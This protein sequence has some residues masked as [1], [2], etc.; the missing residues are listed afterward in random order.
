MRHLALAAAVSAA[1]LL[2]GC[3]TSTNNQQAGTSSPVAEQS[4]AKDVAIAGVRLVDSYTPKA[5]EVAIAY[6]K[7]ELDNGLTVI[8]H[9]DHSDPLVDVDVTYHVGSSR[10]QLGYSGFAHFFEHMMFQGSKHV[11]D[12][13]HFKIITE[14]GGTLNG[15]TNRDRT[16]YFETVPSN[17]LEKMLWLE[18]DRMGFLLS[19]IDETKFENQRETVKNERGQRVDNRPY[20]RFWEENSRNMYPVGHPYSWPTI[21]WMEDLDRAELKLLKDFFLRWYGPNNAVLTIGGDIDE[22]QTL[23]MVKKYF[24]SIPAGPAVEKLV[25][26]EVKLDK[27]RFV[28][29][30]DNIQLPAVV[31]TMPTVYQYHEDEAALDAAAKV[32]GQGASSMMYQRLVQTGRAVQASVSHNC[33]ELS[34]EMMFVVIQNVGSGETLSQMYDEVMATIE[35]FG[36][37]GV[38][39]DDLQRLVMQYESSTLFSLESVSSRVRRLAASQTFTGDPNKAIVQTLANYKALTA[40]K[41]DEKYNQYIAGKPAVVIS[42]VPKGKTDMV[43]ATPNYTVESPEIGAIQLASREEPVIEDS[44]DRSVMPKSGVAKSVILPPVWE[45]KLENG[46]KV[47]GVQNNET[48]TTTVYLAVEAGK[49]D[50]PASVPGLAQFAF[51]MMSEATTEKTTAQLSAES[52]RLGARMG[53]SSGTYLSYMTL[54]VPS[55]NLGSALDLALEQMLTPAFN[56]ADVERIR[57]TKISSIRQSAVTPEGLASRAVGKVVGEEGNVLAQPSIGTLESV[58]AITRDQLIAFHKD[59]ILKNTKAVMVSSDLPKEKVMAELNRLSK[60]Q[61]NKADR[62]E[63]PGYRAQEQTTVYL[64]DKKGAAQSVINVVQPSLKW[65]AFGDYFK[66]TVANYPLGGAFNS[67]INL[68][69]REDKG[70]TYGARSFFSGSEEMGQYMVSTSVRADTTKASVSEI[71]GEINRYIESGMTADE[72]SFT[73]SAWGQRDARN[74][75]TPSKKLGLLATTVQHGV[76]PS[77]L[78]DQAAMLQDL[79]LE[80]LNALVAELIKPESFAIIVVGD[81]ATQKAELESLGYPVVEVSVEL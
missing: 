6:K 75:E 33:S 63:M 52:E 22:Q 50:N 60:L 48:P 14:A 24:G 57:K 54:S 34:C 26:T 1:L 71:M 32:L 41:V 12:E 66:A 2:Q 67:R 47:L 37:T 59:H 25:P 70:Y 44:F 42:I 55:R 68:N 9:E 74:Y 18:A 5:G 49:R 17:E 39:Q 45:D 81:A 80:Q 72:L 27:T 3:D 31:V 15:T 64:V 76:E 77:Y 46:L 10:E 73:K 61:V 78:Q 29:L 40:E 13:E 21:G 58:A 30:E 16:N 8:L 69:L 28:T 23:E 19:A 56:E 20:G 65:D 62:G 11:A 36:K 51:D 43:A 79:E 4:V 7:Y 38:S 53:G 35:E